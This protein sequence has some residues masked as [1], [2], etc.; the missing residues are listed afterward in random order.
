MSHGQNKSMA[1]VGT[2]N[3]WSKKSMAM[4][5]L[6]Q[7]PCEEKK[8]RK[9]KEEKKETQEEK[10]EGANFYNWDFPSP[11]VSRDLIVPYMK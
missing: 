1:M 9:T 10:S 7:K 6:D 4:V 2:Q 3:P 5:E 11:A 8:G